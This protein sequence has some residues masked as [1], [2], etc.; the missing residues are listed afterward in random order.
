[1]G[2]SLEVRQGGDWFPDYSFLG[3]RIDS[4]TGVRLAGRPRIA[5]DRR[6]AGGRINLIAA[7]GISSRLSILNLTRPFEDQFQ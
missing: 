5:L 3:F 4:K 2:R 7:A 6:V 1:M